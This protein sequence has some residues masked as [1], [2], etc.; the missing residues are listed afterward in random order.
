LHRDLKSNN[1]FISG[2]GRTKTL[3]VGDFGISKVMSD[4]TKAETVNTPPF[5]LLMGGRW[6]FHY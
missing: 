5:F 2:S 1:I 3:K 6:G 4:K